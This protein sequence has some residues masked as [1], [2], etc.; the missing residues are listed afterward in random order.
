MRLA[1]YFGG[2]VQ[3][4]MNLQIACQIKVAEQ[5]LAKKIGDE[6][7]PLLPVDAHSYQVF[8]QASKS[9]LSAYCLWRRFQV[10]I[11]FLLEFQAIGGACI[12]GPRL[13]VISRR[14][15]GHHCAS[16]RWIAI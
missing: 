15:V 16:I 3:S 6:V 11:V 4:W 13:R 10:S 2:D 14:C 12:D 7:R 9:S 8:K 5:A 1:R